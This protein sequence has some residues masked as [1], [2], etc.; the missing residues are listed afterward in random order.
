VQINLKAGK[1]GLGRDTLIRDQVRLQNELRIQNE[2]NVQ[3]HFRY[4]QSAHFLERKSRLDLKQCKQVC[5]TLDLAIGITSNPFWPQHLPQQPQPQEK[6]IKQKPIEDI[7]GIDDFERKLTEDEIEDRQHKLVRINEDDGESVFVGRAARIKSSQEQE[8]E[9]IPFTQILIDLE[10]LI[11][12]LRSKHSFCYYCSVKFKDSEDMISTCPG[13]T[14]S[15][16]D[17]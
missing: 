6:E 16:H 4:N 15:Q 3:S 17:I 9:E 7:P 2:K 1:G 10:Q 5:E 12:Y 11:S 14:E 8:E 13:P